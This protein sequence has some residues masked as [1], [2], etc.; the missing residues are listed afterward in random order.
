M[1]LSSQELEQLINAKNLLTQPSMVDKL[2]SVAENALTGIIDKM[3]TPEVMNK[4]ANI[5]QKAIEK[6]ASVALFSIDRELTTTSKFSNNLHKGLAVL[7]GIGGGFFGL[8]GFSVELPAITI[9][10][11][12]SIA[13]IA[14]IKGLDIDLVETKL[15]CLNVLGY[16]RSSSSHDLDVNNYF[17]SRL[18]LMSL[19]A[20]GTNMVSRAISRVAAYFAMDALDLAAAQSIPLMGAASGGAVNYIF[21]KHYQDIAEGYFTIRMLERKYGT[22]FIQNLYENLT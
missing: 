20:T 9:L 16:S 11:L 8:A 15:D 14:R 18:E 21:M 1:E 6:A 19:M 2:N 3:S 13:D 7:T 5:T 12:R 22:R 10:I 4:I 17:E